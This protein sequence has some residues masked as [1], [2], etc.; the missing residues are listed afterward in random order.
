LPGYP[1][2]HGC[3]RMPEELA[4]AFYQAVDVGTPV[5]VLG[6]TPRT[7]QPFQFGPQQQRAPWPWSRQQIGPQYEPQQR[8]YPSRPGYP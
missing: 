7:G 2:S 1:A 6:R 3:V 5:T 8:I 4:V